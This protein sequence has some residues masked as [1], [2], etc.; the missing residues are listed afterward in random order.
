VPQ[1]I[2]HHNAVLGGWFA[3]LKE[4]GEIEFDE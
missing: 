4:A 1:I 3:T 2:A